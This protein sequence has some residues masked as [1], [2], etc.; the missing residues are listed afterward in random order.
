MLYRISDGGEWCDICGRNRATVVIFCSV[1]IGWLGRLV[2]VLFHVIK[3]SLSRNSRKI[4][5]CK[6]HITTS[7]TY[8][9]TV[10]ATLDNIQVGHL[11]STAN[12]FKK[13]IEYFYF[14]IIIGEGEGRIGPRQRIGL[15][16]KMT[17]CK[18]IF[19]TIHQEYHEKVFNRSLIV[20]YCISKLQFLS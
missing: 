5:D 19:R 10:N 20:F 3:L 17:H 9:F 2:I 11:W 15:R 14:L 8:A 4:L 13:S 18:T 7:A 1:K 12:V 6:R 16:D